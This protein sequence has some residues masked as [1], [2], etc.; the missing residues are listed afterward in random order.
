MLL[1]PLNEDVLFSV[2]ENDLE[3]VPRF[4]CLVVFEVPFSLFTDGVRNGFSI[5]M[6][7]LVVR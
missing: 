3:D 6:V 4:A 7:Q 1:T 2:L 5:E